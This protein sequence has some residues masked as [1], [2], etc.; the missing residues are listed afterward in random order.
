[1]NTLPARMRGLNTAFGTS[2]KGVANLHN[3][4]KAAPGH[5]QRA[6]GAYVSVGNSLQGLSARFK[7]SYQAS[8]LFGAFF[9]AFTVGQFLHAIYDANIQL[10]KLQKA[11]LFATGSFEGANKATDK[12]IALADDL[13]L[14]LTRPPRPIRAS[15]SRPRRPASTSTPR[16]RFST[17]SAPPFRSSARTPTRPNSPSTA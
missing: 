14:A 5:A 9:S 10:L 13:G 1:M 3:N 7:L 11:M 15:P 4:L 6:A 12:F 16:T 2:S 8:T 17:A